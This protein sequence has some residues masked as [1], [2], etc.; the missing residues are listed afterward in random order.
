MLTTIAPALYSM[1]ALKSNFDPL[2]SGAQGRQKETGKGQL[3]SF[4]FPLFSHLHISVYSSEPILLCQSQFSEIPIKTIIQEE[5]GRDRV[6][7]P[8][9]VQDMFVCECA[10]GYLSRLSNDLP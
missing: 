5:G 1:V 4:L 7:K 2:S 6:S 10:C 8:S 9:W 3:L